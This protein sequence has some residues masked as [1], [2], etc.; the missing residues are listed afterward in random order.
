V[1][2]SRRGFTLVEML[3]V[4][5][6]IGL[7]L[8]IVVPRF[9]VSEATKARQAADQLARDLEVV[10]SRALASRSLARVAFDAAAGSYTAYLD[11]DRNGTLAQSAAETA[12]LGSF[13]TRALGGDV[14]IG[15]G[16]EPDVPGYPAAGSV[17][18][19]NSRVDF[20][21]RGLTT[22]LG[23]SG[24]VYLRSTADPSALAA[25]SISAAS[26]IRV[27]VYRGGNWQ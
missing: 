23:T 20:D 10:R 9:R 5:V 8:G 7:S 1:T 22:P 4:V 12:A 19:Q 6:L 11:T 27:W 17:T 18:L 25:V 2:Q 13:R 15:R 21:S 24:V 16:G 14:Q 3:V 26:G